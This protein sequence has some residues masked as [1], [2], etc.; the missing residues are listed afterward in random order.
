M[1]SC[2][3]VCEEKKKSAKKSSFTIGWDF[4]RS[5]HQKKKKKKIQ[6]TTK[7]RANGKCQ[8]K[9]LIVVEDNN[10]EKVIYKA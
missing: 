9:G 10:G 3:G 1:M 4:G 6:I 5:D 8:V 7:H 2:C